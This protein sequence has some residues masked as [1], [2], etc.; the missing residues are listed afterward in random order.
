MSKLAERRAYEMFP[1]D[2]S[3]NWIPR[4]FFEEGYALAEEELKL[5]WEDVKQISEIITELGRDIPTEERQEG[6]YKE[7]L[8]RYNHQKSQ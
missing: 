2:G 6:F 8:E 4:P 3:D 7:V 1:E 5:K